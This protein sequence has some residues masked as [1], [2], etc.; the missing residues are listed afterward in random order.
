MTCQGKVLRQRQDLNSGSHWA[1]SIHLT[2]RKFFRHFFGFVLNFCFFPGFT[3]QLKRPLSSPTR[4]WTWVTAVNLEHLPVGHQAT[5]HLTEIYQVPTHKGTGLDTRDMVL[6]L[7]DDSEEEE[8]KQEE[9]KGQLWRQG[10]QDSQRRWR[11]KQ[12][13]YTEEIK[14]RPECREQEAGILDEAGVGKHQPRL[15]L[16]PMM[17]CLALAWDTGSLWKAWKLEAAWSDFQF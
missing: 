9:E 17:R 12:A 7:I 6:S 16:Q 14:R 13:A 2:K 11:R 3:A 5:P 8:K 15:L 10:E 1:T 4:N